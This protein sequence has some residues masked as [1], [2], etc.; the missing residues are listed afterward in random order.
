MTL[1]PLSAETDKINWKFWHDESENWE[2]R[3]EMMSTNSMHS[4]IHILRDASNKNNSE[5]RYTRTQKKFIYVQFAFK[6]ST[7]LNHGRGFHFISLRVCHKNC[8]ILAKKKMLFSNFFTSKI[9]YFVDLKSGSN[10]TTFS[11][12]MSNWSNELKFDEFVFAMKRS[13]LKYWFKT[14]MIRFSI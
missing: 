11:L 9:E 1:L 2:S 7:Y 14:E 10:F 5:E 13:Q 4:V 6:R 12:I 3:V 8:A